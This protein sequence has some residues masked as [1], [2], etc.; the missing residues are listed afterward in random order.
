MD[1]ELYEN[2]LL[3]DKF[4]NMLIETKE[5]NRLILE[6]ENEIMKNIETI[7][8]EKVNKFIE[9]YR[10]FIGIKRFSIPVIG[11]I[12]SGKSTFLN[13]F[14]K[15]NGILQI[16]DNI[17]TK[18]ICIIRHNKKLK[19]PKLYKAIIEKRNKDEDWINKPNFIKGELLKDE[20]ESDIK[21]LIAKRNKHI[22]ETNSRLIN[23]YF[24]IL[25]TNIPFFKG[26][27]EKY[28]N[29][30]EFMDVP[31]LNERND[32]INNNNNNEDEFNSQFYFQ[33]I[34]PII[35][36]NIKFAIF[37]FD[38][39]SYKSNQVKLILNNFTKVKDYKEIISE[40]DSNQLRNQ[41][42]SKNK[43]IEKERLDR[44]NKIIDAYKNSLFIF[45]KIDKYEDINKEKEGFKEFKNF[46]KNI[47]KPI[48][49]EQLEKNCIDLS[50]QILNLKVYKYHTFIDY[51][52]YILN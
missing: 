38:C 24:L 51:I 18:F 41:K 22:M 21:K 52:F 29:Y 27:N 33:N 47:N 37:I 40:N 12:S 6:N 34:I 8:K 5:I 32:N 30:F 1:E 46:L 7:Y 3:K 10:H 49:D 4:N 48:N 31:G 36:N 20:K 28:G 43:I 13:Y 14:L 25:E 11:E 45:N 17:T 26:E 42:E 23:D 44:E 50:S 9:K 39:F 19:Y 35:Q 16:N 15:L 2:I